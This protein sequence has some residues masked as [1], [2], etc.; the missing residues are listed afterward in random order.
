MSVCFSTCLEAEIDYL[1]LHFQSGYMMILIV[2]AVISS[3]F[4]SKTG[5]VCDVF[6]S[7]RK[8]N[9]PNIVKLKEVIR[10]ND[11]LYFVFEFMKENLYQM[12]KDRWVFNLCR[13]VCVCLSLSLLLY[14]CLPIFFFQP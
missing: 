6:Q 9:H 4:N 8:L 1:P 5:S 12:M 10:E 11:M 2:P 7:L 13:C 14:F 3:P